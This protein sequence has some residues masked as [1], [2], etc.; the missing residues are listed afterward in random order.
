SLIGRTYYMFRPYMPVRFRR[1]LQKLY[2]K[3][4]HRIPFPTWPVDRTVETILNR[5]MHLSLESNPAAKIPFIW[6]WPDGYSGCMMMTHDVETAA[7]RDFCTKLADVDASFG[8]RA[9]YQI[10][11]EERYAV[12][13]GFIDSLRATGSEI[14][15]HGLNHGPDLFRDHKEFLRQAEHI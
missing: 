6:F 4:W 13:S 14:N 3:G 9:S 12:P 5:M 10:V 1:Q 11:P 15:V 2:L 8:I 7:G